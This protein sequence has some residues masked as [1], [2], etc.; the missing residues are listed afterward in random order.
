MNKGDTWD[1]VDSNPSLN[2]G[3]KE[4][5][6]TCLV[7]DEINDD[8][9]RQISVPLLK[10]RDVQQQINTLAL[11]ANEKRYQAY[12]LEQQALHIMDQEVIYTK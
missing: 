2:D 11:E 12:C 5:Y 4:D 10:N 7:V 8:H 6:I 3:L 1:N 9:V